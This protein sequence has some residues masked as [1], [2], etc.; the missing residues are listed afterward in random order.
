MTV[1]PYDPERDMAE[2]MLGLNKGTVDRAL[3][4]LRHERML[5]ELEE[6]ELISG[7]YMPLS[8]EY[9]N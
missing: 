4:D 7:F 1:V 9:S 2:E 5:R 6:G 3:F 8:G